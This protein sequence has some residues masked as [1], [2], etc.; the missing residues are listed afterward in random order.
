MADWSLAKREGEIAGFYVNGMVILIARGT[1]PTP[2][3]VVDFEQ[4]PEKVLPPMFALRWRPEGLCSQVE[5][6]YQYI[7]AFPIGG[8][9]DT[10]Q[11]H[12][13]DGV[14]HVKIVS[15]E[16][17]SL[18]KIAM[19]MGDVTTLAVGEESP[20]WPWP[21][22]IPRPWPG[23]RPWPWPWPRPWP[24]PGPWTGMPGEDGPYTGP[25][26]G[27]DPPWTLWDPREDGGPLGGRGGGGGGPFGGGGGPFG[28]Y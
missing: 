24:W 4:K 20:P 28:G 7:E 11:V 23:P 9:P 19:G 10:L 8:A 26:I 2:C 13:A 17:N 27:E 12:H 25:R 6:P 15:A 5:T 16:P 3:H 1:K 14:D 18:A 21:G 22:P